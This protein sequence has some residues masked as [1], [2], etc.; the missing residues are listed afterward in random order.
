MAIWSINGN[1]H[2]TQSRIDNLY[3]DN[4]LKSKFYPD[5]SIHI[6]SFTFHTLKNCINLK[7]SNN[8]LYPSNSYGLIIC[9]D[10]KNGLRSCE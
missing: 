4:M 10:L 5:K 1:T 2:A 7:N 9:L 6:L 8:Y 3:L